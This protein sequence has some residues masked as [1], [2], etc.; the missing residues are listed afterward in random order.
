MVVRDERAALARQLRSW[1]PGP[2][3]LWLFLLFVGFVF[4]AL[5]RE[6]LCEA[7]LA[8]VPAI[9]GASV[10]GTCNSVKDQDKEQK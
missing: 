5:P 7:G 10:N 6:R 9:L 3:W 2:S 4:M 8:A 1:K